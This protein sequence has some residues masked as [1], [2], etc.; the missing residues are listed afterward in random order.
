MAVG[1]ID[2]GNKGIPEY[3]PHLALGG[4][5]TQVTFNVSGVQVAAVIFCA[6]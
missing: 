4:K 6:I 3:C 1:F 2:G 5:P